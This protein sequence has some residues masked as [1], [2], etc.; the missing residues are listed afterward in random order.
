MNTLKIYINDQLTFEYD[1]VLALNDNQLTFLDKMD[2]DLER[3]FKIYGELIASPDTKQRAT[4]VVM[5]LIKALQQQDDAKIAVSC[6]YLISRLPHL[7]E[8]HANEQG[9]RIN[10]ELIEEH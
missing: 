5:N 1:R 2:S 6:A 4:F 7:I 10:I 9:D 8:V 3:G